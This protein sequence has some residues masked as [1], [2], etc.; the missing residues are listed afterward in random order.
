MVPLRPVRATYQGE[1]HA[2]SHVDLEPEP[3][4]P[5]N[6]QDVGRFCREVMRRAERPTS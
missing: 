1:H 2:F 4:R 3:Y 6:P 5:D